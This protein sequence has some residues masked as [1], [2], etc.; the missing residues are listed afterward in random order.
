MFSLTTLPNTHFLTYTNTITA[1]HTHR[2]LS[3]ERL[4]PTRSRR[5]RVTLS[6]VLC[7]RTERW[8]ERAR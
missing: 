6:C 5:S 1:F 4:S 8:I 7:G 3:E 2:W